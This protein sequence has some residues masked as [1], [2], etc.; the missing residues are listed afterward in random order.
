M[1][2]F[3]SK[4]S[5]VTIVSQYKF[6]KKNSRKILTK[7]TYSDRRFTV[8]KNKN[9]ALM[10]VRAPKHFK[11][12]KQRVTFFNSLYRQKK[13]FLSNQGYF[14]ATSS[15]PYVLYSLTHSAEREIIKPDVMLSRSIIHAGLHFKIKIYGWSFIIKYYYKRNSFFF[16]FLTFNFFRK[17]F[18]FK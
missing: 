4:N 7:T 9:T 14:L 6:F 1:I 11:A 3:T 13:F 2:C 17:S 5:L 16:Y 18:L 12:G 10:F 15:T 8:V